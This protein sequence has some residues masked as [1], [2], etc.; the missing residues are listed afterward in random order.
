MISSRIL[1]SGFLTGKYRSKADLGDAARGGMVAHYLDARGQA[2][3]GVL[4]EVADTHGAEVAEVSLAWLMARDGVT[5]PIASA[6]D[7]SQVE[8]FARA[9]AL[10]L[11]AQEIARL[12]QA[13][14]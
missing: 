2:I 11:S 4:D 7:V 5:A 10:R 8:T 3:L 6:T 1:A 12:D 9:A 13:G 14:G